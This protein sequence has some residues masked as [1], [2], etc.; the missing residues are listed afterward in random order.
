MN[1]SRLRQSCNS[2]SRPSP[3][4]RDASRDPV[5]YSFFLDSGYPPWADSGMTD[6][7]TPLRELSLRRV[8]SGHIYQFKIP[9]NPP[10]QKGAFFCDF[11]NF[12]PFLKGGARGDFPAWH[13]LLKISDPQ[14]YEVVTS[15]FDIPCSI[16]C[17]S[18][19]GKGGFY[20]IAEKCFWTTLPTYN[21]ALYLQG[22]GPV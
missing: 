19:N 12:P 10:L 15:S 11:L 7:T 17:C 3:A 2:S 8:D 1:P 22:P 20:G 9:L 5:R 14:N 16:F 4:K 13:Q 18:K 21:T 6:R